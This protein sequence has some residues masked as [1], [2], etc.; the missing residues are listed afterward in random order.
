M[1]TRSLEKVSKLAK[2]PSGRINNTGKEF[3]DLNSAINGEIVD[4]H[5]HD[6]WYEGSVDYWN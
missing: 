4:L 1:I 3:K 6:K 2:A 5:T